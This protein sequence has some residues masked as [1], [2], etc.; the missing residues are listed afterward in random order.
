MI[1]V[2][3]TEC[4]RDEQESPAVWRRLKLTTLWRSAEGVL[5]SA[6]PARFPLA[7]FE[8]GVAGSGIASWIPQLTGLVDPGLRI[9][10]NCIEC[11]Y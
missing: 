1:P 3:A 2:L 8:F 4:V 10:A 7:I 11:E 6:L 5:G 9:Y